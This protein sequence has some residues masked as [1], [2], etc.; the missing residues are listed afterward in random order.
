MMT[1]TAEALVPIWQRVLRRRSIRANDNFFDLGGNPSLAARLFAEISEVYG[2]DLP[3][4]IIYSAPTI[5]TLGALL[6]RLD[7]PR[8]P[9]LLLLKSGTKQP[10]IFIAHGLGDTVF[11]LFHLVEKIESPRSIYGM[12]TRG[13][14]GEEEPFTSI[15]AM[16]QFHLDAIKRLQPQGPYFLIGYSLG[17]LVTLEIAQSL[18][19]DGEKIALLALVDSYPHKSRLSMPQYVRLSFRLAKHRARALIESVLGRRLSQIAEDGGGQLSRPN[20]SDAAM[21]RTMRK[22]RDSA[23][24]ALRHYHPR[25]YGGRIRFVKAEVSTYFPN[26][27]VAVWSHLAEKFE[28]ETVPGDHLGMIAMHCQELSSVLSKYLQ[29]ACS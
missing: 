11:G 5:A 16:A 18:S 7:P 22:M 25:F 26:D 6:E 2:R 24:V 14:D 12:Q 17:G 21:D 23:C 3:P 13:I 27:P 9:A 20:Q 15:E 29:E 10:P 8:V 4:V 19:A 28:V 1:S